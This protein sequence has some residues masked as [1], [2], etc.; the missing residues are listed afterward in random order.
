MFNFCHFSQ[1]SDVTPTKI[2]KIGQKI[3]FPKSDKDR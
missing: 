1:K 3:N 2:D